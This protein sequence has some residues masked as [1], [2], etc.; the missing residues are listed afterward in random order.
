MDRALTTLP[1]ALGEGYADPMLSVRHRCLSPGAPRG[2]SGADV[3]ESVG[4]RGAPAS[5]A[6]VAL[7]DALAA[8]RDE[9]RLLRKAVQLRAVIEQAK[10]V[11]VERHG[12]TLDEAFARLRAMSQEH[13]VRLVEVAA[14]MVGVRVPALEEG[15]PDIPEAVLR[16]RL[17]SSPAAPGRGTSC[18]PSPT[19]GPESS[20]PCW[21]QWPGPRARGT[22]R[23]SCSPS[24]WPPSA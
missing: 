17:P 21:T 2:R 3:I 15:E 24:C 18:G 7:A 4:D 11:L 1:G 12:I 22:T 16:G 23:P 13:N 6:E 14:T 20:P 5:E 10:G 9:L 19:S 8:T